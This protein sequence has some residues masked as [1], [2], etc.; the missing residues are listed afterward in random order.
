MKRKFLG[1]LAIIAIFGL[2]ACGSKQEV[3]PNPDLNNNETVISTSEN[4]EPAILTDEEKYESVLNEYKN[5]ISEFSFEDIS[6]EE[7]IENKYGMVSLTLIEHVTRYKD[8][9]IKLTYNFYDIDKNGVNELLVG[10]S[11]SIGA[12]YSYDSNTKKPTKVL[13]QSTLERGNLDVYDNGVILSGGAGGAALH[14]YEFGKIASNGTSYELLE[15]IEEEYIENNEVPIYRNYE[16]GETL[17]YKDIAEIMDKYVSNATVVEN[18]ND[19][20]M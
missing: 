3:N 7:S 11:G 17:E 10:A 18:N 8:D 14:Y 4:N 2:A 15:S 20:E 1:I 9:G 19:I 13:F 6:S 12:I 5:A 16:T